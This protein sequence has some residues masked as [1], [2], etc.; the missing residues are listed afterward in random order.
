[1]DSFIFLLMACASLMVVLVQLYV[2]NKRL[3]LLIFSP[4]YIVTFFYL[5]SAILGYMLYQYF[6]ESGV[7]VGVALILTDDE[8]NKTL[9][10]Y[11]FIISIFLMGAIAYL[12]IFTVNFRRILSSQF[13]SN[14]TENSK[15]NKPKVRSSYLLTLLGIVVVMTPM[16]LLIAGTGVEDLWLRNEYIVR[17]DRFFKGA[18]AATAGIAIMAAGFLSTRVKM[19]TRFVLL[20]IFF[21]YML[22][23][24]ALSSRQFALAPVLICL[25]A[26]AGSFDSKNIKRMLLL[27]VL[28]APYLMVVPLTLRN[29]PFQGFQPLLESIMGQGQIGWFDNVDTF[30]LGF[31]NFLSSFP[32]TGYSWFEPP[33]DMRYLWISINPA[34]S[35]IAGWYEVADDLLITPVT[36][37]NATGQLLNHGLDV[38]GIYYFVVGF[39]FCSLDVAIRKLISNKN[40]LIAMFFVALPVLFALQSSQYSLRSATRLVYYMMLINVVLI[41]FSKLYKKNI[42]KLA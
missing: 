19:A 33:F 26:L 6:E 29:M 28:I 31:K 27:S 4:V 40:Y 23:F 21:C 14:I 34:P 36:M 3:P 42:I 20:L 12:Q 38:A 30:F 5:L 11:L 25:G 16:F 17:A 32:L 8:F 1:M 37:Y 24:A 10:G 41:V 9:L 2:I 7:G 35:S 13:L 22:V 15:A 39:Y 18:G